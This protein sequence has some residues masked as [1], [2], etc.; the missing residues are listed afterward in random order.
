LNILWFLIVGLIAGFLARAIVPG[1][2][3]MGLVATLIL[4]VVGSF[5][6]GFIFSLFQSDREILD[7]STTGLIGSIIGAIVALLIYRQIKA[8]A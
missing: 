8:R 1:K 7:F 2:D 3:P 5:V 6:G 4:G